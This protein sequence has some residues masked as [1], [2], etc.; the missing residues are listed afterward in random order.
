MQS[1]KTKQILQKYERRKWYRDRNVTL[2]DVNMMGKRIYYY[3]YISHFEMMTKILQNI[4]M[5]GRCGDGCI[6][7]SISKVMQSLCIQS[8]YSK[9][10]NNGKLST[11]YIYDVY[12]K[13]YFS[14]PLYP[15]GR[16]YYYEIYV[17]YVYILYKLTI[18]LIQCD[19]KN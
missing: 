4:Q 3:R 12:W 7:P 13:L 18:F 8:Q 14:Y 15:D 10:F 9:V 16:V 17:I 5:E 1:Y 19:Q 2:Q 11:T 6:C